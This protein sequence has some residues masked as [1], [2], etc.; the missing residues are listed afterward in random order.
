MSSPENFLR[1]LLVGLVA[2][3]FAVAAPAQVATGE[4]FPDLAAAQLEGAL[5][6]TAGKVVVVDFWAS[7]C[8]PCKASFPALAQLHADYAPRGVVILGVSEDDKVRPYEQFLKKFAPP[9]PIVRDATHALARAVK[10]PAMPTTYV[11]G[12][13]G[14]VR[15]IFTGYHGAETETALRAALDQALAP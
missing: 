6:D 5:P 10:P 3:T 11:V 13:D 8:A 14:L 9:F 7:W 12:R 1:S 2:L 4:R 15:A